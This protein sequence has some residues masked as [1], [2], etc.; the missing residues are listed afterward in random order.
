MGRYGV[1]ILFCA[2]CDAGDGK[3]PVENEEICAVF[4]LD[5][6]SFCSAKGIAR[7]RFLNGLGMFVVGFYPRFAG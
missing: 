6:S 1:I 7:K 4:G 3:N 5:L 2:P